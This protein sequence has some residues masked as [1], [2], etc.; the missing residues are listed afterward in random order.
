MRGL[1]G[2]PAVRIGEGV[3]FDFSPDGKSVLALL[4]SPTKREIVIYPTGPGEI[5]KIPSGGVRP[6][7]AGWLPDGRSI[8]VNGREN[9]RPPRDFLFDL[10]SGKHRAVSP[11]GYRGVTISKDGK[12]F[13]TRGPEDVYYFVSIEG[14]EPVRIPGLEPRDVVSDWADDGRIYVQ[15]PTPG[16]AVLRLVTLDPVTG[17]Q[18]PW[19]DLSPQDTTGVHAVRSFVL[20]RDG[21]YAYGYYRTLSTLF[22][23]GGPR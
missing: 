5:R 22:L 14:G 11:E 1:D 8:L 21:A 15:K 20:S 12:R 13:I 17:R 4:G 16:Q 2:S 6:R 19:R 23:V 18:Q 3:G 9:D 7:A 10:A